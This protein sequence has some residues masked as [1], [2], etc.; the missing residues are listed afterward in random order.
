M[1]LW[2]R[3][4]RLSTRPMDTRPLALVRIAVA[5]VLLGDIAHLVGLGVADDVFRT[6]ADG[7]LSAFKGGNYMLT[8]LG[9]GA[10]M[11]AL[12]VLVV[13]LVC[14]ATGI[15]TRPAILVA[16]LA[17]AQLGALYP[18]GDRAIDRFLRSVL[19]LLLFSGC[20]TRWSLGQRLRATAPMLQ[21][22]A[23]PADMLRVL[24]VSIYL[25]SGIVKAASMLWLPGSEVP[26]LYTI[27]AD[28]TAGRLDHVAWKGV[29]LPF[30][31]GATFTLLLEL[32]APLLLFPR[33]APW[34]GL[35]GVML[36]LGIAATM[37]L[38]IFPWGM[39][40][41]YPVLFTHW[42]PSGRDEAQVGEDLV[43]VPGDNGEAS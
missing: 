33:L 34:W 25:N 39:L 4:A 14:V 9:P 36:H 20:H 12:A 28:P 41:A 13:A 2:Q 18:P 1:R 16:V 27:L 6:Y 35:G 7:G 22:P 8:P 3:W 19:L 15:G 38:G 11:G 10:G 5:L 26:V 32:S 30:S 43:F 29:H 40:A 37:G 31:V 21:C 17:Y 24:L 23:W 42:L